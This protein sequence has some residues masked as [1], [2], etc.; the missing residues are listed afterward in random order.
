[1]DNPNPVMTRPERGVQE[2]VHLRQRLDYGQSVEV[3]FRGDGPVGAAARLFCRP[4]Y[5]VWFF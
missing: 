2:L 1:V 3:Q 5:I 4:P